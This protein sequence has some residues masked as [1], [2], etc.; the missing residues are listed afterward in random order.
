M[1]KFCSKNRTIPPY[2]LPNSFHSKNL[3]NLVILKVFTFV[4]LFL[5]KTY[6]ESLKKFTKVSK[7]DWN[8]F[9]TEKLGWWRHHSIFRKHRFWRFWDILRGWGIVLK[10]EHLKNENSS[11]YRNKNWRIDENLNFVLNSLKTSIFDKR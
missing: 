11:N 1:V 9:I 6:H 8:E 5:F 10:I 2:H 4:P 7:N 3:F